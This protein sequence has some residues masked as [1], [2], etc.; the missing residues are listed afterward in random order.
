MNQTISDE[1][2]KL[3]EEFET[4]QPDPYDDGYGFITIG[5]GHKIRP[6]E[7]FDKIDEK[8]AQALLESDLAWA[9]S[10]VN[11]FVR[12]PTNQAEF[13]ALVMFTFNIG[14]QAFSGSTMLKMLNS[15][16]PDEA[17]DE[18]K[19]WNMSAGRRSNGLYRR[20]CAEAAYFRTG[21]LSAAIDVWNDVGKYKLA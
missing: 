8:Q 1:G 2:I 6:G 3:L 9:Q 14:C 15:G 17:S 7:H 16:Q 10:C 20:R 4:F 5:Y 11:K 12:Y 13:D 21:I 18:F 19:K